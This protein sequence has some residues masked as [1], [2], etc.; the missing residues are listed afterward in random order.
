MK[1]YRLLLYILVFFISVNA[2]SQS[3]WKKV[4]RN[5]EITEDRLEHRASKPISYNLFTLD[6]SQFED[7][8]SVENSIIKLPTPNGLQRFKIKEASV[9]S[10]ELAA[11]Y[12]SIKSY[13]GYGIDDQ[14]ARARISKSKVGIHVMIS[15]G[16]YP[17]Y[18]VDPYTKDKKTAIAYFKKNSKRAHFNCLVEESVAPIKRTI[19]KTNSAGDGKLRTYR[20]ALVATGAYSQFHLDRQGVGAGESDAT[21]KAAVLSAINTS[22]TRI[23]GIFERDLS[24]TMQ[25]VSNNENLIFLDASTDGLTDGNAN[26]LITEVQSKIDNVIGNTNYD[27][28]HAF[29]KDSNGNGLAAF[30]SACNQLEKGQGVSILDTPIDDGF[31]LDVSAHEFGHQFGAN[32]TQ[33]SDCNRNS[34]TAVEPGSGTT[35]MGYAGWCWE[36]N[37][38]VQNNS[39]AYFHAVSIAEMWSYVSGTSCAVETTT[40]NTAPSANA[41]NDFTIPKST[42]FILTGSATD[43]DAG[44]SLTYVWEQIDNEIATMPLSSTNTVGPLFRS[45]SPSTSSSRHFPKLATVLA[46]NTSTTWE[47]LPSVPRTMEFA[48]T[49]RDNVTNGGATDRDDAIVTVDG[50]SGPFIVTSQSTNTTLNGSSTQT[51]TWNVANT[52]AA[53]VSCANVNI[54]LST[55]G[56]L[57]Y[58]HV[59]VSNTPNDG[60]QDVTLTNETT[61]QA[62]IKIE[63]VGNIFYAVN[64]TN[65]S[66]D[67]TTGV[68]DNLFANFKMYP[69]PSK[70][71]VA[72]TFDVISSDDISI[73]LFDIR[74]RMID[75]QQYKV[76]S[77]TF[78]KEMNYQSVAKG[79]YILKITNGQNRLSKK[80][81]LE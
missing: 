19:S 28:G 26:T 73:Q 38:N 23:N 36:T 58:P 11:K 18:L 37:S 10:K 6:K 47:V 12:P 56:G 79:I 63:A 14:T 43:A 76:T 54:L 81:I 8:I 59:L 34:A 45:A 74:G 35:I 65:F 4:E 78:Q 70:G 77:N 27:V 39:D 68:E 1:N 48:F 44:N 31:D 71:K 66:I 80:I 72:I 13:V 21:K 17:L 20:L 51:I 42:P 32:H 61:S 29:G 5:N 9:F 40:G 15:S 53:P 33:N 49:V 75:A 7:K 46:G 69:N 30:Q 50:N 60:T 22:I 41:G 67:K 25:L 16:N 55:D 64:S 57:T 52:S 24:I 3:L 62:R 2:F